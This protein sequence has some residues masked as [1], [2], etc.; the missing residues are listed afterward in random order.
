MSYDKINRMAFVFP[1]FDFGGGAAEDFSFRLPTGFKGRLVKIGVAITEAFSCD[2]S[3]ASVELGVSGNTDA[4]AKLT[5]ADGAAD[6]DF[7]DE[8]DDADAIL[9]EDIDADTL[10][11][12]TLTNGTDGTG[13]TGKGIPILEFEIYD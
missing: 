1:E 13:V 7:F 10:L 9:A 12:V 11:L 3:N 4:Y 2:A 6:K 8:T 5:I